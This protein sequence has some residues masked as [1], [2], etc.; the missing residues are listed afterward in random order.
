VSTI[1][2][3]IT[4]DQRH[5]PK[6]GMG[7]V[8]VIHASPD[9]PAV[10]VLAG[11][12]LALPSVKYETVSAYLPVMPGKVKFAIALPG[13]TTA[14][15]EVEVEVKEGVAYTVAAIGALDAAKAPAGSKALSLV[16]VRDSSE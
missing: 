6:G 3:L 2:A 5:E 15:K 8:R 14:V 1:K 12:K 11:G 10:D 7:F 4:V 9:A 16:A 13:T